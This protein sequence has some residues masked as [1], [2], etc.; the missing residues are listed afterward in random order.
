MARRIALLLVLLVISVAAFGPS[1]LT[2]DHILA[3][4]GL[5]V[6]YQPTVRSRIEL[7]TRMDSGQPS[8][9][10]LLL[11]D[12]LTDRF[13]DYARLAPQVVNY[14]VGG[15][16]SQELL[17][18]LPRYGL[19]HRAS[20][21]VLTIGTNDLRL[22]QVDGIETRLREISAALPGPMIWNA[23]PPTAYGDNSRVNA[24][25]RKVC[26]DRPDCRFLV[27]DFAPEDFTDG[28]HLRPSGYAKWAANLKLAIG[29]KQ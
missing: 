29:P 3:K 1:W 11:G 5:A 18:S 28:S 21:I 9:A 14:G 4:L 26:A 19:V 27:T 22:D 15:Q 20:L 8:G 7:L 10:V 25:A 6:E 12:S 24:A 16:T 13:K 2:W 17:Q 23:I